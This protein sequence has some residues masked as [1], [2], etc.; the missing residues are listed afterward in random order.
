MNGKEI[1][2][3]RRR[4][5]ITQSRLAGIAGISPSTLVDIENDRLRLSRSEY[6]R[7]RRLIESSAAV[8]DNEA[9]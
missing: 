6:S 7:L 4:F 1:S 5:D 3:Q 9:A 8:A 2:A